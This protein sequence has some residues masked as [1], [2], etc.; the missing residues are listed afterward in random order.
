MDDNFIEL[1]IEQLPDF[2]KKSNIYK[3]AIE[4]K[5]SKIFIPKEY[6]L[7]HDSIN[8]I[9]VFKKMFYTLSY[10]CSS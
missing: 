8:K 3:N 1:N 9:K 6:F 2:Y 4:R 5:D 10:I 7:A